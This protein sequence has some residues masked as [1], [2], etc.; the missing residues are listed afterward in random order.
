MA[1]GE[2]LKQQVSEYFNGGELLAKILQ[3]SRPLLLQMS[4]TP[5]MSLWPLSVVS[6]WILNL[7]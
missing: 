2:E 1:R 6:G 4:Q 7:G 5:Y 3:I